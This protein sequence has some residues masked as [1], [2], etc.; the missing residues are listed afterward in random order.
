MYGRVHVPFMATYRAQGQGEQGEAQ[1][2]EDRSHQA[3]ASGLAFQ[4]INLLC[5]NPKE[6]P[7]REIYH[8]PKSL[9]HVN[10]ELSKIHFA[11]RKGGKYDS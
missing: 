6:I 10:P 7:G 4:M 3:E 11:R 1:P 5:P 8:K 9:R 2:K